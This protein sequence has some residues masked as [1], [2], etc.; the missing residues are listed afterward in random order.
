MS[1]IILGAADT[2]TNKRERTP[3]F[4]EPIHVLAK[5]RESKNKNYTKD[6]IIL[7]VTSTTKERCQNQLGWLVFPGPPG[8]SAKQTTD[9][10]RFPL[11]SGM[12]EDFPPSCFLRFFNFLQ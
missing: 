5:E 3:V 8:K 1:A 12:M 6:K 11:R 4:M 2:T 7:A 9:I 10:N